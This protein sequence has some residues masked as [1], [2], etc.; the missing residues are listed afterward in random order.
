VVQRRHWRVRLSQEAER[1]FVAIIQWT[2]GR[3]D[4]RQALVY[5]RTLIAALTALASDPHLPDSRPRDEI[6]PGLHSLHVARK[7]RRG[8]H[9]VLYRVPEGSTIEVVWILYDS[10]DI[11][12]HVPG[13]GAQS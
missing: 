11:E 5:R 1:D 6:Q 7:G 13:D 4:R 12:Q 10:M 9:I 3:F 8:R 2:A